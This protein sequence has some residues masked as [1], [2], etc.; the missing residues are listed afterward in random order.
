MTDAII[1]TIE[2]VRTRASTQEALLT[3]AVP[4]EQGALISGF[5]AKVGKQVGVAFADVE[6]L[7]VAP[8]PAPSDNWPGTDT[9]PFGKEAAHLYRLGFFY[10][11]DVLA[12]I[13]TDEEYLA[14]LKT[15][16]CCATAI[17]LSGPKLKDDGFGGKAE[18]TQIVD[19]IG[20]VVP[21]HVRWIANGAGTAI[22]PPYSA[23]PLCVGHHDLQH[24]SGESAIGGKAWCDEQRN[25]HLVK[26]ASHK[27]ANTLGFPSMGF[28]QP[29]KLR[30]WALARDLDHVLPACYRQVFTTKQ[31]D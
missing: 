7:E 10:N 8:A 12:A 17:L 5:L 11:P 19:H 31:A 14:W 27:L 18:E 26:W 21:A 13:G 28:V 20:D 6:N 29:E 2:S 15:Q 22:K 23:I 30:V 4:I 24:Q 1:V 25:L 16:P 9:K 3:V